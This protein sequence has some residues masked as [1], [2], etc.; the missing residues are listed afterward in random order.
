MDAP[1]MLEHLTSRLDDASDRLR[2]ALMAGEPTDAH[3]AAIGQLARDI[4]RE[5]EVQMRAEEAAT[6]HRTLAIAD[7]AAVVADE[8]RRRVDAVLARFPIS[9][10]SKNV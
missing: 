2:A 7:R 10:E 3:R 9:M 4:D 1:V 5:R 6:E 8:V